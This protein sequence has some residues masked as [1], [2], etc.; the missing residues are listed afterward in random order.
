MAGA[1]DI[2]VRARR[3]VRQALAALLAVAA[4]LAIVPAAAA[5]PPTPAPAPTPGEGVPDP[6]ILPVPDRTPTPPAE[7]P[8]PAQTP[9]PGA[10]PTPG[11][12]PTP[13]PT[14]SPTPGPPP[15][16]SGDGDIPACDE[17]GWNP[18]PSVE[19]MTTRA[20]R[21]VFGMDDDGWV[22][23][24]LL[25]WL[26]R[27]PDFAGN[28]ESNIAQAGWLS[29]SIAFALLAAVATFA[30]LHYWAAGLMAQSSG[31]LVLSGTLRALGAG[32]FILAWPFIFKNVSTLTNAV[33]ATLLPGDELDKAILALTAAGTVMGLIG[34]PKVALLVGIAIALVFVL[35]FLA[36]LLTK[37]GLMAGLLIAY[38]GVPIAV[39]LWPVPSLSA[40]ATYAL[41]FFGMVT[42]VLVMWAI[43][44]RVFGA[45]NQ[46]FAAWGEGMTIGETLVLPLIGV[47]QLFALLAIPRH[48]VAMWNIAAGGRGAIAGAIGFAVHSQISNMAGRYIPA[49]FGG[50]RVTPQA[51]PPAQQ[52]PARGVPGGGPPSPGGSPGG[53]SPGGTPAPGP[54]GS[55]PASPG[56][57]TPAPGKGRGGGQGTAP[58]SGPA[59][60]G[61]PASGNGAGAAGGL[62]SGAEAD[63][64]GAYRAALD[65]RQD[66]PPDAATLQRAVE[67]IDSADGGRYSDPVRQLV[68][69]DSAG[70]ESVTR[71]LAAASA[72]TR[73]TSSER[74]AFNAL[75][76]ATPDQRMAALG[77]G[78]APAAPVLAPLTTPSPAVATPAAP[79]PQQPPPVAPAA[80][81][82][83][84]TG[85]NQ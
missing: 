71:S 84:D 68:A 56:P 64:E 7:T 11:S 75:A 41:R 61:P 78:S 63:H 26:L 5:D 50:Q 19:C 47:A 82:V 25:S 16:P 10:T 81:T 59:A 15:A 39:A 27:I 48:A 45:V 65:R 18:V 58:A 21:T 67:R 28:P 79:P 83:P 62:P 80:P 57:A 66:R 22:A 33:T 46:D 73:L 85:G 34:G 53:G 44:F 13:T 42:S 55:T 74:V 35:L 76:A 43:A 1:A 3:A 49:R 38:V 9:A 60:G 30:V 14:P 2:R 29:E 32:L 37:L 20:V 31:T 23:T 36:L 6:G 51:A 4:L 52:T 17:G 8:D 77:I 69:G 12:T 54:G 24:P 72:D 70:S 40:P